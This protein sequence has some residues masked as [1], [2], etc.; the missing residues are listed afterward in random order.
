MDKRCPDCSG[1]VELYDE[2]T[3]IR[4]SMN[5]KPVRGDEYK[6]QNCGSIWDEET[7]NNGQKFERDNDARR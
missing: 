2:D 6:C 3:I 1:V 7:L 4:F 5:G